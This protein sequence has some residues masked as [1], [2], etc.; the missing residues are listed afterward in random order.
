MGNLIVK[1]SAGTIFITDIAISSKDQI[2][3][4]KTGQKIPN[5]YPSGP[6]PLKPGVYDV[7]VTFKDP[8]GKMHTVI[9]QVSIEQGKDILLEIFQVPEEEK[10]VVPANLIKS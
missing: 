4:Q 9:K 10:I 7:S 6:I 8:N 2:V 1:N 5:G 3:A